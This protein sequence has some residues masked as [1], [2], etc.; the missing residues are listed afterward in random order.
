MSSINTN[1]SA[2]TALQALKATQNAMSKNQNQISTGLRVAEASHNASYWSIATG[3]KSDNGALGAVKDSIG[4]SVSTNQTA[5][6]RTAPNRSAVRPA[7][8]RPTMPP[9]LITMRKLTE[10]DSP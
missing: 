10:E 4:Q 1:L 8:S 3:M 6:T 5:D 2:M 9:A 7:I